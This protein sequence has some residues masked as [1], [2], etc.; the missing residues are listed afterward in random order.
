[1]VSKQ[2]QLENYSIPPNFNFDLVN[3]LSIE[4]AQK[5]NEI[6]PL[7]LG[8]ALRISGVTPSAIS[9]LMIEL[10]RQNKGNDPQSDQFKTPS[11]PVKA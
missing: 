1:M 8:Q 11:I 9:I 3:S 6:R 4:E 2:K 10:Q 7:T 5:L